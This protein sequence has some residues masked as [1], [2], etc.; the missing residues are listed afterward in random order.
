MTPAGQT[1]LISDEGE[2]LIVYNDETGLSITQHSLAG[3]GTPTIGV[4]RNLSVGI[5]QAESRYLL[6]NDIAK[7]EAELLASFP[8][9]AKVNPVWFDV[10]LMVEFNTGNVRGWPK[11]LAY[12]Q[13]Q[14]AGDAARELLDSAAAR[15]LTA[16]YT[17][18]ALAITKGAW[19]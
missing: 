1:Q 2:R 6:A 16:R 3:S 13:S 14:D 18:M 5:T 10:V 17:R 9:L 19:S 15:E 12:M 11:M 4:G 7:R 8:W